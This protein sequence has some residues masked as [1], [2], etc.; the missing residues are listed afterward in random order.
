MYGSGLI[1]NYVC[2]AKCRHCMFAG[3]PLKEQDF[4]TYEK[5]IEIAAML[6]SNGVRSLHIGGGE[7]FLRFDVLCGAVRALRENAIAVDY[8]ETNAFWCTSRDKARDRMRQLRA[9]RGYRDGFG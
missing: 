2:N 5:A 8:I 6:A 3:A 4:I 7:P 9:G 1:T